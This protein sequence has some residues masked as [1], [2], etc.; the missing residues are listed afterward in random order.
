MR[1]IQFYS[2]CLPLCI[3]SYMYHPV[4]HPNA[5]VWMSESLWKIK[6]ENC[7]LF[8]VWKVYEAE[9]W[10][11]LIPLREFSS[12]GRIWC[13]FII[14]IKRTI[15]WSV[16]EL[17][18]YLRV[19]FL[20]SELSVLFSCCIALFI[21]FLHYFPFNTSHHHHYPFIRVR[22]F[23]LSVIISHVFLFQNWST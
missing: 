16:L 9:K 5:K 23:I 7:F 20:L 15:V 11:T 4:N 6:R 21:T 1:N 3:P 17:S 2:A 14:L 12:S 22:C 18:I 8:P 10:R 13:T 19:N